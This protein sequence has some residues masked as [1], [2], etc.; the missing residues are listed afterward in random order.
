MIKVC[1]S[2]MGS[3]KSSAA[4]NYMNAHKHDKKF[5]YI[6]PYLTETDRI[7]SKCKDLHFVRPSNKLKEF[8]FSKSQHTNELIK[9]GRNISTTHQAFKRYTSETLDNIKK[10]GYTLIIDEG[11]NLIEEYDIHPSDLNLLIKTGYVKETNGI[12]TLGNRE[13]D[14]V[15]FQNFFSI[16]KSRDI[17]SINDNPQILYFWSLPPNLLTSFND[18]Y[19]LTYIFEAQ[20]LKYF[21]DIYNIKYTYI[22]IERTPDGKYYFSKHPSYVPEYVHHLKDKIHILDNARLNR[23][24]DDYYALSKSWYTNKTEETDQLKKNISNYFN[25]IWRG[26]NVDKRMWGAF[27]CA[28]NKLKG[29]GYTKSF[30]PFNECATNNYKN[31][32][33]L[34]YATNVFMNVKEKLLYQYYGIQVNEDLYALSTMVQWIWRSAI[35]DGQ[36][37][38]LYIPSKRMRTL[39]INWIHSF[40]E[41]GVSAA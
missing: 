13:Y 24:G 4:I 19:I 12:Y 40:D 35:R 3:G 8:N 32:T 11:V 20:R 15:C 39:L 31:K 26:V 27:N 10:Q 7:F 6:T 22:G 30:V 33:H 16:L 5:I 2:I 9:E 34:V 23:I 25:N 38:Y 18:V 1:D 37:I 17:M 28:F 29:K 21:M 14:G 36:D 41:G